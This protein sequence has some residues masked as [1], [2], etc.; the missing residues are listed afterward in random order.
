MSAGNVES[1][2]DNA[3]ATTTAATPWL[4]RRG[5]WLIVAV[6]AALLV[7][8]WR[9]FFWPDAA[10]AAVVIRP[11]V[12]AKYP[13]DPQAF[14]Q[15]LAFSEGR[16]FEGTGQ[17]E[18]S[19]L[20]EV[21]LTTG[22]VLRSQML[23][24]TVF[25]EGITVWDKR[26]Y[27]V[28]WRS[29]LGFIYDR[30]TFASQGRFRYAGEGWGL[31]HDEKHLILSDGTPKLRF[32]DPQTFRV[33]R[34]LVVRDGRKLVTKINELEYINGEIW[35]NIWHSDFI[36]RISPKTGQVT[37]WVDLRGLEPQ[38]SHE[39]AVLNGIAWDEKN[40]KLYVTGKDWSNIYEI[41]LPEP[42]KN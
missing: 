10:A 38:R 9:L 37:S 41:R 3:N 26:I 36:A 21:D 28:S 16:L 4:R 39:E 11:E 27:Q 19:N 35:A 25:G 2:V 24:P 8:V 20:R 33:V 22:R 5:L 7:L 29:R 30:D 31:T 1:T 14:S 34:T 12:V 13:H 32:L 42:V 15:G 23:P 18:E 6:I 40:G 17:F